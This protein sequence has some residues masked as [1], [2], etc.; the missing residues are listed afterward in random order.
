MERHEEGVGAV[1]ELDAGERDVVV[2]ADRLVAHV[3]EIGRGVAVGVDGLK[4]RLGDEPV[5]GLRMELVLPG[6]SNGPGAGAR[7]AVVHLVEPVVRADGQHEGR[8]GGLD[9]EGWRRR[10]DRQGED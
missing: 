7:L 6:G 1:L 8:A 2:G 9:R 5:A 4:G 10:G 3:E